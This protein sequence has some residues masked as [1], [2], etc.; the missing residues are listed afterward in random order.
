MRCQFD[1]VTVP[2]LDTA[3]KPTIVLSFDDKRYLFNCG[4]ATQRALLTKQIPLRKINQIFLSTG[5]ESHGGLAGTMLGLI[6]NDGVQ[7]LG[8]HGPKNLAFYLASLR[9]GQQRNYK[10]HNVLQLSIEEYSEE[11][12][13]P[14]QD[15]NILVQPI[16]AL[17]AS[18][19]TS[20]KPVA[21]MTNHADVETVQNIARSV[22]SGQ[23]LERQNDGSWTPYIQSEDET[24]V[25]DYRIAESLAERQITKKRTR[26]SD[27]LE[28][29]HASKKARANLTVKNKFKVTPEQYFAFGKYMSEE[30]PKSFAPFEAA[31]SYYIQGQP[32]P[33]K[34]NPEKAKA[35]GVKPG[36]DYGRLQK[37][38]SVRASS[39]IVHPHQ[40]MG[41]PRIC[42]PVLLIDCPKQT[43]LHA[44]I[45][46]SFWK[47]CKGIDEP[48]VIVHSCNVD[49]LHHPDYIKFMSSFGSNVK[50]L[51]SSSGHVRD[52]INNKKAKKHLISLQS[53]SHEM[54]PVP[55]TSEEITQLPFSQYHEQAI[56]AS[57]IAAGT[58][59]TPYPFLAMFKQVIDPDQ[60]V[61]EQHQKLLTTFQEQSK[62]VQARIAALERNREPFGPGAN[63]EVLTLGTGSAGPSVYRNVAATLIHIPSE[64]SVLLDCGEGTLGQLARTYGDNLAKA[65]QSLRLIFI[66]HM[67]ADHHL[68]LIGLIRSWTVHNQD[69]KNELF[70]VCPRKFGRSIAEYAQ[71]HDIGLERVVIINS[72]CLTQDHQAKRGATNEIISEQIVRVK[73]A[74]PG[75]HSLFTVSALHS[76]C[77][78]CVRLNHKDGWSIAYSGDTRPSSAFTA[79]CRGVSCLIHE[80]TFEDNMLDEAVVKKHSTISEALQVAREAR[81]R[82]AILTHFSQRYPKLPVL[83][84][85]QLNQFSEAAIGL[86]VDLMRVR[87]QDVWK[88]SHHLAPQIELAAELTRLNFKDDDEESKQVI[89]DD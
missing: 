5:W 22:W 77:A 75:L 48:S 30:L 16:L 20:E 17:G 65:L 33:G 49:V 70:V 59:F 56:N 83:D 1:I 58:S 87:L 89:L 57:P 21:D 2:S 71:I 11:L 88:L 27:D 66:S 35:L 10:Y 9:A 63:V 38:Q 45:N 55:V 86:A 19:N 8:L 14:F 64:F 23:F 13:P 62:L 47:T 73:Q 76:E 15:S 34:F 50:H 39:G 80:A 81:A 12:P 52:M 79:M 6:S 29:R 18:S 4:E 31:V 26:N 25:D 42:P 67:H 7:H 43:F 74:L 36:P 32:L 78:M 41:T 60:S 82:C 61:A 68:G 54:Y 46:H 72:A 3:Q 69:N 28:A 85:L 84:E 44:L 51:V 40:V 24:S 53:F 37:G